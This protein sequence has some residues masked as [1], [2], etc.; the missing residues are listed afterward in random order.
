MDVTDAQSFFQRLSS[1][2]PRHSPMLNPPLAAHM[3]AM[4]T[5]YIL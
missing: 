2:S 1:Y 3:E 4:L 5:K